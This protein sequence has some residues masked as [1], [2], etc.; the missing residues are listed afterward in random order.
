MLK[1]RLTLWKLN[2]CFYIN[3]FF[4]LSHSLQYPFHLSIYHMVYFISESQVW[5]FPMFTKLFTACLYEHWKL[6]PTFGS[7]CWLLGSNITLVC[8]CVY[9]AHW[10]L[11]CFGC[12]SNISNSTKRGQSLSSESI[13]SQ[14]SCELVNDVI[15]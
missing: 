7:S 2:N 14:G 8:K 5:I 9:V 11:F 12:D 3:E 10:T 4:F 15:L 6:T 1:Q 13:R